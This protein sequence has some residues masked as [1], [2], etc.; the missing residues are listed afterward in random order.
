MKADGIKKKKGGSRFG[1]VCG[2]KTIRVGG[3]PM[4]RNGEDA[5]Q[6]FFFFQGNDNCPAHSAGTKLDRIK[7]ASK[8]EKKK[9]KHKEDNQKLT[10]PTESNKLI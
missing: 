3:R 7:I 1:Y 4:T 2:R 5:G 6:L 8:S 9:M 10:S